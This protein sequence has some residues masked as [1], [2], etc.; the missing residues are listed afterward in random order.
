[1]G[2]FLNHSSSSHLFEIKSFTDWVE[3]P[4]SQLQ[5]GMCLGPPFCARGTGTCN[6]TQPLML[7]LRFQTQILTLA[8]QAFLSEPSPK[9]TIH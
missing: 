6:H 5:A 1:M 4:A 7:V 2:G 8:K 9:P 3:C